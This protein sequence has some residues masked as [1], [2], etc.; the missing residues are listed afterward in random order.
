MQHNSS[1]DL[2]NLE[3]FSE[4]DTSFMVD[5]IE[6]FLKEAESNWELLLEHHKSKQY[7]DLNFMSHKI[8]S[9][10]RLIGNEKLANWAQEVETYSLDS[11]KHNLID[12]IVPEMAKEFVNFI[13]DL[14][15]ELEKLQKE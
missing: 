5:I 11:S 12:A 3:A 13:E 15:I 10:I 8:K 1:L 4:G 7:V 9:A 14:K 2:S 6:T